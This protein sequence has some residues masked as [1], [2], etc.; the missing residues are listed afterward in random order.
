MR[1]LV[2]NIFIISTAILILMMLVFYKRLSPENHLKSRE[3]RLASG[4]NDQNQKADESLPETKLDGIEESSREVVLRR[5]K[6][7]LQAA[8]NVLNEEEEPLPPLDTRAYKHI[9]V[10]DNY[11]VLY[12]YIPK[13]ACTNLKRI[14]LILKGI[15]K[16]SNPLEIPYHDV[17]FSFKNS[18][19]VLSNYTPSEAKTRLETYNKIIFVREPMERLLSAYI[20]KFTENETEFYEN[21]GRKIIKHYRVSP[22]VKSIEKGHDVKFEEFLRYITDK[23]VWGNNHEHWIQYERLCHPCHVQYDVIG[24]MESIDEDTDYLLQYLGASSKVKFPKRSDSTTKRKTKNELSKYYQGIPKDLLERVLQE[25]RR[26][27][28]LFDYKI[29]YSV[30]NLRNTSA[31]SQIHA[32]IKCPYSQCTLHRDKKNAQV[33]YQPHQFYQANHHKVQQ[34]QFQRHRAKENMENSQKER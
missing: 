18:L 13:V 34:V 31:S 3:I 7:N 12:C 4:A 11:K 30:E 27:Y 1:R 10:D 2:R 16:T 24:K 14:F 15:V 32:I 22:N 19:N 5:R 21:Y 23:S 26:D 29:P 20:N 8:C 25:F 28:V 33:R 6:E 17:H 9:V